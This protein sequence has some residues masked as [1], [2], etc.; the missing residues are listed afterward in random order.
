MFNFPPVIL[1]SAS[2]EAFS[3]N[4]PPAQGKDF[5]HALEMT[6]FN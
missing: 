2:D 3:K 1:R 6:L 4:F 5:S